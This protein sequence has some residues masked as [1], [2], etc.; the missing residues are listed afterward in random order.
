MTCRYAQ[1][2]EE[3]YAV[4][5]DGSLTPTKGPVLCAWAQDSAPVALIDMPPWL[6]RIA[7]AGHMLRFP[8]DCRACPCY[9][10]PIHTD[11]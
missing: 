4:G 7:L 11:R 10:E 2:S 9:A 8:E 6:Q 1:R 3:A 5:D